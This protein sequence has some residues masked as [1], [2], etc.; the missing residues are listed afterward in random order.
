MR[1]KIRVTVICF[2]AIL[3]SCTTPKPTKTEIK[4]SPAYMGVDPELKPYV[5]EYKALAKAR[6][7]IFTHEVTVG[8]TKIKEN[9]IIGWCNYGF[10]FREIDIDRPFWNATSNLGK[11]ML[12]WHELSHCYCDRD[13]DYGKNKP[14][15]SPRSGLISGSID[16]FL[17]IFSKPEE[18]TAGYLEDSCP[19]SIMH[20]VHLYDWCSSRHYQEYIDEMFDRCQPF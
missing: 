14:Y 16:R 19:K 12:I 6:N 10:T 7:L 15:A 4:T 2:F 18:D 13:H 20:P 9:N 11:K 5:D 3:C 17:P 8:F 1:Q